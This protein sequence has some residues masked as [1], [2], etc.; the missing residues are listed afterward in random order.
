MRV[1]EIKKRVT[2]GFRIGHLII[3]D[4]NDNEEIEYLVND[5]CDSDASGH[6][7]G[8]TSEWREITDVTE[9]G[10]IMMEEYR[11]LG[12]S[13]ERIEKK[14]KDIFDNLVVPFVEVYKK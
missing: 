7:R 5:W 13:I 2:N 4:L 12:K 6:G 3:D 9:K 10:V 11:K 8:W 1:I 14:R